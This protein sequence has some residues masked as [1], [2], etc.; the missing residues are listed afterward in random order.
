MS[1]T[2]LFLGAGATKSVQGLSTD[3]ILPAL[4]AANASLQ[5][6]D[7]SGRVNTLFDFLT[8][9]FHV[10]PNNLD[11][12][13]YPGLPLLMSLIDTALDRREPLYGRWDLNTLA[14][15]R[16]AIEF[17]IFDALE[18]KLVK[19]PTNNHFNMFQKFF[20]SA[21]QPC[22][23]ST[24]YDLIADSAMMFLSQTRQ[25]PGLLPNYH[26]G[27]TNLLPIASSSAL[28]RC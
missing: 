20:P 25:P 19:V 24:N 15:L 8:Q 2:V 28:E 21:E 17:G 14:Q 16:E 12:Y 5:Q 18:E 9:E 22:V 4:V 3:E 11:K 13:Q 10:D 23:I 27:I 26:C 1:Q 6:Q 7:P